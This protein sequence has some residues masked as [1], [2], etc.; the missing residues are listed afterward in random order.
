MAKSI[1]KIMGQNA[2]ITFLSK[3]IGEYISL[4]DIAKYRNSL[5]PFSIINICLN[6]F[7]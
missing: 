7:Y 3:E 1:S 6:G 4:T 5:E 2:K